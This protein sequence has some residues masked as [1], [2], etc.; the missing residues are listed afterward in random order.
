M[1]LRLLA[2]LFPCA[3]FVCA[4]PLRAQLDGDTD[5]DAAPP[6]GSTLITSDELQSDQAAHLSIFTGKVVV[7][8]QNF[9]LTC[10]EMDVY[11]TPD[12]KVSRIVATGDVVIT[13]PNRV[14]HCGRADYSAD[15]D[16]FD[17][18]Q[19]PVILDGKNQLSGTEIVIDRKT[20]KMTSKGPGRTKVVISDQN[21]GT[22]TS[23]GGADASTLPK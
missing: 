6:L 12:N 14:T 9:H 16:T 2:L 13:Q 19:Q 15:N 10:Q 21:L 20:Q 18:T 8:G 7:T 23:P 17:L 3:V 1:K 22:A 5:S 4:A 11:F